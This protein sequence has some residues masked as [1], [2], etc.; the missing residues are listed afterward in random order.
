M[1][2][3][4]FVP[5]FTCIQRRIKN[6]SMMGGIATPPAFFGEPTNPNEMELSEV[7]MIM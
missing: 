2:L 3:L 6:S 7:T 4:G 5:T 1:D